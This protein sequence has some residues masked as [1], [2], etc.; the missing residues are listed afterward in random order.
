[1]RCVY[2]FSAKSVQLMERDP[3]CRSFSVGF[4]LGSRDDGAGGERKVRGRFCLDKR[5]RVLEV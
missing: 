5:P 1:M 3:V 4:M 2:S